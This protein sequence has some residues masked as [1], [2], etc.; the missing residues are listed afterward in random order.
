MLCRQI[1]TSLFASLALAFTAG[2]EIDYSRDIR[3]L[4]N[5]HCIACHGGVK[6]ESGVSFLFREEAL[7]TGK[8]GKKTVVPGQPEAS[9]LIARITTSDRADLMP[10]PKHG[11]PLKPEE[12]ALFRQWIKEGAKWGDHWA[13]EKPARHAAPAVAQ[14]NW[15]KRPVDHFI[16]ARLEAEK[17]KPSAPAR[18]DRLLRRLSLDLTGLPPTP[19]E[20]DA[21]LAAT[22]KDPEAAYE[23]EVDR[24]LASP[25]FGER[26]AANWLDLARYADSEGLGQDHHRPMH[27]Y[28]DWV[29][30]SFNE[31]LPFDE[32]TRKQIAGDLFPEAGLDEHIATAFH[33]LTQSNNEG[34][35]DD[36]EFRVT[37]V[38]DRLATTWETWQGL[39][40][41]CVQCHSHPYE[42]IRHEEYFE[43]FAFFNNTRDLDLDFNYPEIRVPKKHADYERAAHLQSALA[44]LR[45]KRHERILRQ[46]E[47]TRW[48]PAQELTATSK[49]TKIITQKNG[50]FTEL[51]TEGTLTRNTVFSLTFP[52]AH[53]TLTALRLDHL[54]KDPASAAHTPEWGGSLS[55]L[56]LLVHHADRKQEEHQVATILGDDPN[57]A[58]DPAESL[59]PDSSQGWG[60]YSKIFRPRSAV[61]IPEQA[62]P[63]PP[64]SRIELR[65]NYKRF[66]LASFPLVA[67]RLRVASSDE[68]AWSQWNT[69]PETLAENAEL[70][71]LE[72][73]LQKIPADTLPVLEELPAHLR[74]ET[75]LFERGNWLTKG[76]ENL[77]PD[78]PASLPALQPADPEAPTRLDLANWLV[79]EDNPLTARVAVNRFWQQLFGTG[80]V[81]TLEDFGSSGHLPSHPLLL[82]DLAVRFQSEMAWRPKTLIRELVTSATYRQ[83]AVSTAELNE[84]D[85]ANRLLAR[86][87]RQRLSAEMIRDQALH[88][89]GLLNPELFGPATYP[90]IAPGGYTPA[91]GGGGTKWKTP[92]EGDPQ[93]YRRAIY[94]YLKRSSPYPTLMTFDAP[95]REVC[96]KRRITSN[97]PLA[98]LATLNDPVFVECARALAKRLAAAPV[99]SLAERIALGYRLCTSEEIDPATLSELSEL[100]QSIAADDPA[101][102][103]PT[104]ASVLLNLDLTLTK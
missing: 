80:L 47:A 18:P 54:P 70:R 32:F 11:P 92:P 48:T 72:E 104:V 20:L 25:H 62:I 30:R 52:A 96:T 33:R 9:E 14:K 57:P 53:E 19:A 61:L 63:L 6:K 81:A 12:I 4:I 29:I 40:F 8:S 78:T 41:G 74:R 44:R 50:A 1:I 3:P 45:G 10:P 38:M 22:K 91:S 56:R 59:N 69:L 58:F 68:P 16:L 90:P 83:S 101:A 13:F 46:R 103:L 79:R 66:I 31:D 26:W 89:S 77:L 2:A 88:V 35:T 87:P 34:G 100:H 82:D 71:S 5:A 86:G 51:I 7:A 42:P 102:A 98:A 15:V 49:P 76:P 24:L 94:I 84:K 60:P 39:T 64:G 37:A 95:T 75:R 17:L 23:A 43:F 73:A 93:R 99:E 65:L 85:P 97:T 55:G 67:Q 28:R 27:P 21:F 36:E